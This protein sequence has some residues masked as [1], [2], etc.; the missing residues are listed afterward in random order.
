MAIV[1]DGGLELR[2]W[3]VFDSAGEGISMLLPLSFPPQQ[4]SQAPIPAELLAPLTYISLVG[5][6]ISIVASLLTVLL[7]LQ[8]RYS[9]A[10][11]L[12][13]PTH[14]CPE[15]LLLFYLAP[16]ESGGLCRKAEGGVG[17]EWRQETSP[18]VCGCCCAGTAPL[19]LCPGHSVSMSPGGGAAW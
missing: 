14:C 5:C 16:R 2:S 18:T 11:M 4:L 6:S 8:A 3:Q 13:L 17:E 1:E 15:C 12:G 7:H 19:D 9:P 10:L